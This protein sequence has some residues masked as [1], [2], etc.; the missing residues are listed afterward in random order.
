MRFLSIMSLVLA[1]IALGATDGGAPAKAPIG[2]GWIATEAPMRAE[3]PLLIVSEEATIIRNGETFGLGFGD[4]LNPGDVLFAGE[5]IHFE[6]ASVSV[7]VGD[8]GTTL[9]LPAGVTFMVGSAPTPSSPT[10]AL[11]STAP[12]T[13]PTCACAATC[14]PHLT[15]CGKYTSTYPI[16]A[17]IP[18]Q[19]VPS[20]GCHVGGGPSGAMSQPCPPASTTP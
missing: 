8:D 12:T 18:Q 7:S 6:P 3:R 15:F 10:P 9:P 11:P 2:V 17:C 20:A 16:C 19:Q 14:P 5:A 1:S 13:V 4:T